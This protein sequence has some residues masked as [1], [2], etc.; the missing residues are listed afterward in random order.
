MTNICPNGHDLTGDPIPQEYIDAGY[1][2]SGATHY[3]RMIGYIDPFGY[4][5]ILFWICPDCGIKWPRFDEP[6]PRYYAAIRIIEQPI[7]MGETFNV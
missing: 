5:G 1:Y 6:D 2:T 7:K 4:D 3:S